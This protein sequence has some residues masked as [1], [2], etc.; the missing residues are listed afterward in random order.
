MKAAVLEEI[1]SIR[2]EETEAP[3]CVENGII[4][5]VDACAVCG[6]DVKAF[7][8][9][10]PAIDPPVVLGH[11]LVGT[12]VEVGS[13]V[14]GYYDSERVTVAPAVPCGS[15]SCCR[16]GQP[17]VCESILDVGLSCDGGFAEYMLVPPAAVA[18]GSVNK[19]PDGVS[20]AAAALT[21]PLACCINAHERL[22]VGPGDV[23]LVIGCGPM[24]CLNAMLARALG[25]SGVLMTDVAPDRL[26]LA[27]VAEA[28]AYV[29][30]GN[31]DLGQ[32]VLRLS[33]ERGADV[34]I[35]ACASPEAQES[36]LT[37]AAPG[38]RISF[39]GGLAQGSPPI[40]FDSNR[41][42]YQELTVLGNHGSTPTQNCTALSLI[43]SGR[44]DAESIVTDRYGLEDIVEAFRAARRKEGL[45]VLVEMHH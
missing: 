10:H 25:A 8:H 40:S 39:F 4:L 13:G 24:G 27:E 11:E 9:G 7:Q 12:V 3:N 29:E 41:L 15:C 14:G 38:G 43:A 35:V 33:D 26:K 17:T 2:V 20:S 31:G 21:E 45:K 44:V 16:R 19:V 34:I 36:A 28:D 30:S 6:T 1:G 37:L 22:G 42:H 18:H 5:R 23:V 32:E